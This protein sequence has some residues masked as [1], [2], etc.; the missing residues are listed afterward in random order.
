MARTWVLLRGLI[1]ESRHWEQFPAQFQVAFPD[2][3]V[4]TLDLPGNGKLSDLRSPTRVEEMVAYLRDS[5]SREGLKP[6]FHVVALSL[7]AMVAVS[8]LHDYP[9]EVA[10]AVLMNTSVARFSPFW[11]RLRVQNYG[12]V[13]QALLTHDPVRKEAIILA[14]TS[15]HLDEPSRRVLARRWAGYAAT[16]G[17]T[18]ANALRQLYAAARFKAPATLPAP[19]P[20]LVLN[21]GGDR[22]VDPRCSQA[23]A[24]AW[25][26][27][28]RVHVD[29]GH[30]LTLDDGEWVLGQIRDWEIIPAT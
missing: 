15:N 26:V 20:V 7:G 13:L 25:S 3:R 27:P 14:L 2:D 21:G 10:G 4:V 18:R 28:L 12:K 30:D 22:M 9:G 1:R 8:W 24:A 5:L 23:L 17:V 19:V 16:H 29:A 11:Q 6:P